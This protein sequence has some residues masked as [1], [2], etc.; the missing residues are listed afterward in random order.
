M[1]VVSGGARWNALPRR[2]LPSSSCGWKQDY[3]WNRWRAYDLLTH[4]GRISMG[5]YAIGTTA[6]KVSKEFAQRSS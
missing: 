4:V 3:G 1:T 5:Y 6:A 2:L